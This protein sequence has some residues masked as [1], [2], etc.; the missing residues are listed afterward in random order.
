MGC[1]S[2]KKV[3]IGKI[4]RVMMVFIRSGLK[5]RNVGQVLSNSSWYRKKV[6]V[7]EKVQI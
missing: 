7:C 1:T 2:A 3:H 4:L 6:P 5:H